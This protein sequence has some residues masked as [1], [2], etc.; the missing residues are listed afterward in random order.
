MNNRPLSVTIIGCVYIVTEAVGF[1]Y[2]F[3]EFKAQHPFQYDIV[4]VELLRLLAILCGVYVLGGHKLGALAC[5]RLDR[6]PRDPER[7]PH[8][9]PVGNSLSALRNPG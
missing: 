6:L 3:T 4:W 7:L 9:V 5:A 8:A 2:H 1:A